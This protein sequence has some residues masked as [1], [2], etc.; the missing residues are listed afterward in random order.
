MRFRGLHVILGRGSSSVT[1]FAFVFFFNQ[2]S[3]IDGFSSAA[4]DDRDCHWHSDESMSRTKILFPY[5]VDQ[6]R[7]IPHL[8]Y[9]LASHL[10]PSRYE[11]TM[12][13]NGKK[14]TVP[15]TVS[16]AT[17]G[18]SGFQA[19]LGAANTALGQ[20]DLLHTGGYPKITLPM[21]LVAQMRNRGLGHVHSFRVDIEPSGDYSTRYKRVLARLADHHV[22]VSEH[23]SETVKRHLGIESDVI[24]NPVDT[25]LFNPNYE[26]SKR[27]DT[28][29]GVKSILF[30]GALS[31]R[32]RP[33]DVLSVAKQ[34]DDAKFFIIG[35]GPQQKTIERQADKIQNVECLG[36]LPKVELPQ[37]YSTADLL[38]FPS[39]REGCPNVV[40]EAMAS[41]TPVCGYN[42]TSMPELITNGETGHLDDIGDVESLANWISS[43]S[44]NELEQ[45]GKIAREEMIDNHHPSVIAAQ[46]NSIYEELLTEN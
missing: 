7:A 44:L 35:D 45:A 46:Y 6:E 40:M 1:L 32:K 37:L 31:Q 41:E 43:T 4:Y 30:V 42:T 10:D 24:H 23:T 34:V 8:F 19:K 38:L 3:D 16:T 21:G 13:S 26:Q 11:V 2:H 39:V 25:D 28:E 36:R 9:Q 29:D 22:S 5:Y 18:D 12:F 14:E 20:F 15:E 17:L 27:V 33:S